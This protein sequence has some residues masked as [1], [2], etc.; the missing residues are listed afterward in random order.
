MLERHQ[1]FRQIQKPEKFL[2]VEIMDLLLLLVL[3]GVVLTFTNR[4]ALAV[5]LGAG[6]YGALFFL[7]QGTPN[8]YTYYYILYHMSPRRLA[9]R[10]LAP[11]VHAPQALAPSASAPTTAFV[12]KRSSRE[13]PHA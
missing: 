3:V 2:G 12:E 11:Q 10:V 1:V 13:E 6:A 7:K 5:I 4:L 8:R 9:P